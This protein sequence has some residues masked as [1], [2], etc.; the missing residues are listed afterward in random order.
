MINHFIQ[1]FFDL[2]VVASKVSFLDIKVGIIQSVI[3]LQHA[4]VKSM[5]CPYPGVNFASH[6]PRRLCQK[7][8]RVRKNKQKFR[9]SVKRASFQV[10]SLFRIV[11]EIGPY[12][13]ML[14]HRLQIYFLHLFQIKII[15]FFQWK[16]FFRTLHVQKPSIFIFFIVLVPYLYGH[17]YLAFFQDS[18]DFV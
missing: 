12:R 8:Q 10:L 3:F 5:T 14:L 15:F 16:I 2:L 9:Q 6:F 11:G 18:F 1:T 17:Q 4:C 7:S 13:P